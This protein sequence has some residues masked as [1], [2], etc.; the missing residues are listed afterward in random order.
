MN[1][2]RLPAFVLGF[3]GCD[4]SVAERV[5]STPG[6]HLIASEN[7]Y[8]WLGHGIYFWENNPAR[9]LQWAQERASRV[10][11]RGKKFEPAVVGA[12]ID[13]GHCLDLMN[14]DS[15]ALVH[16]TFGFMKKVRAKEGTPL[17]EN[18]D[19][20]GQSGNQLRQLDCAVI[21]FLHTVVAK[22]KETPFDSVRAAFLEG[23][24]I[25]PTAGFRMKNH[26]QIC[27]RN[28]NNIRGYFYPID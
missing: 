8:D 2:S 26:I 3:H 16:S 4:R 22:Q 9:A 12:I 28:V 20:P 18:K 11:K 21:N 14:S 1:Y 17:P 13:M 15:I 27:V 10:K 23:E 25:Y 19:L 5:I 24:R 6:Q 7:D